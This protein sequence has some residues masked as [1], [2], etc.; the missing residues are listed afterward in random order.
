MLVTQHTPVPLSPS[1]SSSS[2]PAVGAPRTLPRTRCDTATPMEATDKVCSVRDT[3]PL[4]RSS[5]VNRIAGAATPTAIK[6]SVGGASQH[7]TRRCVRLLLRDAKRC[8]L[9]MRCKCI[10]WVQAWAHASESARHIK[11]AVSACVL[12][13]VRAMRA[14]CLHMYATRV[15]PWSGVRAYCTVLV[16]YPLYVRA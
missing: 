4:Y 1:S 13:C 7:S 15:Y 9:C 8:S 11:A 2:S 3:L 6:A 10:T 14:C 5:T 16:L 12:A